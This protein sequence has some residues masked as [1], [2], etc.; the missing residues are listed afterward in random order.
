MR[1]GSN[2]LACKFPVKTLI[3]K[4]KANR[5]KHL[6]DYEAAK[7]EYRKELIALLEK[8]LK[9]AKRSRKV[10]HHIKLAIP[11]QYSKEYD[12]AISMLELTSDEQ[13][14]LDPILYSQLVLDDWEWKDD[15]LSNTASYMNKRR[16]SEEGV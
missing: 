4:L 5:K 16:P 6:A 13:V 11:V 10:N 9:A 1:S 3:E 2:Q 8:K 7:V 15:F 12:K 14:E